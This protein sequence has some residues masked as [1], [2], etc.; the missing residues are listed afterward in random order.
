MTEGYTQTPEQVVGDAKFDESHSETVT[1]R[2]MEVFSLCEHHLLPFHGHCHVA[3]IPNRYVIGLSKL[4][5]IVNVY[6]RRLQ[7]QERL[8][9]QIADAVQQATDAYGVMVFIS[10]SHM[11]MSMRGVQNVDAQTTTTASR[12]RYAKE[13]DLRSEFLATIACPRP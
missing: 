11:C 6:A 7:V 1:V 12:G 2:N 10:C 5:R 3:Y 9:A 4:A 13:A 8:T